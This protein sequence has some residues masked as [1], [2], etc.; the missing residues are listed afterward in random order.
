MNMINSDQNELDYNNYLPEMYLPSCIKNFDRRKLIEKYFPA[1]QVN[2]LLH[3]VAD[4]LENS[5]EYHTDSFNGI[6]SRT[7]VKLPNKG[8]DPAKPQRVRKE[9]ILRNPTFRY[10]VRQLTWSMYDAMDTIP[11]EY[12]F[13]YVSKAGYECNNCR[14]AMIHCSNCRAAHRQR[15]AEIIRFFSEEDGPE[16]VFPFRS[17]GTSVYLM[18]TNK[19]YLSK[20]F[21]I[22]RNLEKFIT[23]PKQVAEYMPVPYLI[24]GDSLT[25]YIP[26]Y[27]FSEMTNYLIEFEEPRFDSIQEYDN[28]ILRNQYRLLQQMEAFFRS[29]QGMKKADIILTN[30]SARYPDKP[31]P[32]PLRAMI[33]VQYRL[34][35]EIPETVR[36]GYLYVTD[37]VDE[38]TKK[39]HL[40]YL[41]LDEEGKEKYIKANVAHRPECYD[42]F[43][44][45]IPRRCFDNL[46]FYFMSELIHNTHLYDGT[47]IHPKI[48]VEKEGSGKKEAF[49]TNPR[50]LW[51]HYYSLLEDF[52][53]DGQEINLYKATKERYLE[54]TLYDFSF[55]GVRYFGVEGRRVAMRDW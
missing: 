18:L 48:I 46:S 51:I 30:Y 20:P 17:E 3:P 21:T 2:E 8:M 36:V 54:S 10:K 33:G 25:V 15:T 28:W 11:S 27:D 44:V 42:L 22:P 53:R 50:M 39:I 49:L 35:M 23:T 6:C 32:D 5:G 14:P 29:L 37:L 34:I 7:F 41:A 16:C 13:L 4:D 1:K 52:E 43:S 55:K 9:E 26:H 24:D 45:E 19:K 12:I 38:S 47:G 40:N 31:H